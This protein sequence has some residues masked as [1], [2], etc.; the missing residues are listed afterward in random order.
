M[1]DVDGKEFRFT[2]SRD[3]GDLCDIYQEHQMNEEGHRLLNEC[4]SSWRKLNVH[5]VLDESAKQN[6]KMKSEEAERLHNSRTYSYIFHLL[7]S[8]FD[9]LC[10][11][12]Q[13]LEFKMP[14]PFIVRYYP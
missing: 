10:L 7:T 14:L 6:L 8:S 2:W 3:S 12:N 13:A 5:R 9:Y 4:G 11:L 1:I